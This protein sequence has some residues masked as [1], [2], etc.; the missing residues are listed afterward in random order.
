MKHLIFGVIF[1]LI[2][3]H[4]TFAKTAYYSYSAY[5]YLKKYNHIKTRPISPVKGIAYRKKFYKGIFIKPYKNQH[6]VRATLS[7]KV[8]FCDYVKYFGYVIIIS[9]RNGLKTVYARIVKPLVRKN[10]YVKKGQ[11]IGVISPKKQ[12]YFEVRK[13]K[14]PINAVAFLK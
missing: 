8:V 11:I 12:F 2:F 5:H 14:I 13:R 1:K 7:G 10:Y 6:Y 4:N 3:A 9:H